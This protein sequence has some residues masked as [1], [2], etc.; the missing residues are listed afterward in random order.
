[1]NTHI[2]K[3]L[4]ANTYK[5][6]PLSVAITPYLSI[7][8]AQIRHPRPP[9]NNFIPYIVKSVDCVYYIWYIFYPLPMRAPIRKTIDCL[10]IVVIF[11]LHTPPSHGSHNTAIVE[12]KK[13]NEDIFQLKFLINNRGSPLFF[14]NTPHYS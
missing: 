9:K 11:V 13:K 5:N 6:K 12:N 2:S 14:V 8:S 4:Y 10:L 3:N 7:Y 1:M